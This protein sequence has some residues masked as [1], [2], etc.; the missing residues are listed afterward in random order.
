MVRN[1]KVGTGLLK[2]FDPVADHLERSDFFEH[3]QIDSGGMVHRALH[4]QFPLE[5]IATHEVGRW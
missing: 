4:P 3:P 2:A 1:D 5:R